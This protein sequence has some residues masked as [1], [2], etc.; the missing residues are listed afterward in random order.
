M[1]ER[2]RFARA[3][4]EAIVHEHCGPVGNHVRCDTALDCHRIEA[5]AVQETVDFHILRLIVRKPRQRTG[6]GVDRIL[7]DP[8]ATRMGCN[9]PRGK[10]HPHRAFTACLHSPVR[11][12]AENRKIGFKK[13]G[14]L[15]RDTRKRI[16]AGLHFLVVVEDPREIVARRRE[17][18]RER[19]E[20]GDSPLH[21]ARTAADEPLL[22]VHDLHARRKIACDGNGIEVTG[23]NDALGAT[24]VSAR[25]D[26][27]AIA[28]NL[29][30]LARTKRRLDPVGKE[31][32]VARNR[33]GIDD[34]TRE[35]G[36]ARIE[37]QRCRVHH[38][39][40][41]RGFRRAPT[42]SEEA[43]YSL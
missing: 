22:P 36:Q 29:E 9:S 3:R 38:A 1:S 18:A 33:L 14:A 8:C 19:K 30:V 35:L 23:K 39:H 4:R 13:L 27:V 42:K 41:R 5:F 17:G 11:R 34:C 43:R 24:E 26:G 21:V 25:D 16:E 7:S 37:G 40:K 2:L 31:N 15:A 28:N 12:L 10:P 6:K 32:F 20:H